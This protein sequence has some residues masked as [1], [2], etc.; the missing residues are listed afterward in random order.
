MFRKKKQQQQTENEHTFEMINRRIKGD[1]K[2]KSIQEDCIVL[3]FYKDFVVTKN[4]YV[5]G[6]IKINGVNTDLLSDFEKKELLD[7]YATYINN[8]IEDKPQ[9]KSV[10]EPV[11]VNQYIRN[12]KKKIIQELDNNDGNGTVKA[13]LIA[14]KILFL[15][16]KIMG[17]EM[18]TKNHYLI[19]KEKI[20]KN[21]V[22]DLDQATQR[23]S[24]TLKTN[25]S[26]LYDVFNQYDM[27]GRILYQNELF[28][29]LHSPYDYK[30]YN[31]KVYS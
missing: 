20:T 4:G 18:S 5:I 21:N 27:E 19:F 26:S 3:G 14:S 28:D 23:L 11:N 2:N 12:L 31:L 13:Q 24:K 15:Q 16:N 25:K 22:Y 10:T 29:L 30:S 8:S 9:I 7:D 17:D 6:G 1:G